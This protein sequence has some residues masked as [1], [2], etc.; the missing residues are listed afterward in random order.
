MGDRRKR[1]TSADQQWNRS[2]RADHYRYDTGPSEPVE[3]KAVAPYHRKEDYSGN[4]EPQGGQIKC[5]Q[6]GGDPEPHHHQPTSPDGDR[7]DG[8]DGTDNELPCAYRIFDQVRVNAA[9]VV[10][11]HK[12]VFFE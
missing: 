2:A 1:Q 9:I 11:T 3:R 12:I 6:G 8:T 10:N 5:R 7:G 4:R